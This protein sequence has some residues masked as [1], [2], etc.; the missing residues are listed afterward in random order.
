MNGMIVG[1]SAP[2]L[3]VAGLAVIFAVA[4]CRP[5][6]GFNPRSPEVQKTVDRAVKFLEQGTDSRPGA[7]ALVGIALLKNGQGAS[8]PRV[9]Y[10]ASRIR[11]S[12]S[13]AKDPS[14][15]GMD[16]YSAAL[17][18]IFLTMLDKNGYGAE[19]D[20][21]ISHL[22][23][24][25][26]DH[27]GWGYSNRKTGDTSMTQNVVLSLWEANKAGKRVP[28]E[29]VD[30]GLIWLLKTQDPSGGFGYQGNVSKDFTLVQQSEVRSS[31]SGAGLGSIYVCA[32][33]LNIGKA[34][35]KRDGLPPALREI[36]KREAPARSRVSPP[37][38]HQALAR[39]TALMDQKF[40]IQHARLNHASYN[41]YT[42]ERY[43][44]FREKADG[45]ADEEPGWYNNGVRYLIENQKP[46]GSWVTMSGAVPATA[47]G[48]LFL[49][50]STLISLDPRQYGDGTLVGGRG[51]PK[52]T[53]GLTVHRGNVV[54]KPELGS[55]DKLLAA[56]EDSASPDSA[57]ALRAL[58]VLPSDEAADLVS[59][60]V[61]ALQKL[62]SDASPDARLAAVEALSRKRNLDHAPALIYALTDPEPAVMRAARDSLRRISR[63]F[64]GFGL[65]DNPDELERHAAIRKWQAWY[66]AV[67]P[68][69][70][71]ED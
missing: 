46:D 28:P 39:G 49:I 25:Q 3:L 1:G 51:L 65:S 43:Y 30:R 29:M 10:G 40:V 11:T 32:D 18:L 55:L 60:H 23:S 12:L 41:L 58:A 17:C 7:L 8:H 6:S 38:V 19:I 62:V 48:V 69:A 68:D 16:V 4:L 14:Q 57:E 42:Q 33:L 26:K 64:Q 71:F 61:K 59:K 70:T 63:R 54:A 22:Q 52:N 24:I 27:G 13:R 9:V 53:A 45:Q 44:T 36:K 35:K 5:A 66:R 2:R 31:M 47:F 15:V 56:M 34:P 20:L 37:L 67:R 50:R 21:L